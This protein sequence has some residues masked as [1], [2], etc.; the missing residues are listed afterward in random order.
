M[1]YIRHKGIQRREK[2][3]IS[4]LAVWQWLVRWNIW[5]ESWADPSIT[6]GHKWWRVS[7]LHSSHWTILFLFTCCIV[8]IINKVIG[9]PTFSF[10]DKKSL[11]LQS[12]WWFFERS[13]II[14]YCTIN[15]NKIPSCKLQFFTY[16][17]RAIDVVKGIMRVVVMRLCTTKVEQ[18]NA[19]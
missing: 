18:C 14:N 1:Q 17:W 4:C 16:F 19:F 9:F 12:I 11:F 13:E 7:C 8:I 2:N 5:D 10:H 15:F 6:R 3:P